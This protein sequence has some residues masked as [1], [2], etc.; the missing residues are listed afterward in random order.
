MAHL[1]MLILVMEKRPAIKKQVLSGVI[2][3]CTD[4]TACA[5]STSAKYGRND[6]LKY[7]ISREKCVY[8][9]LL[10]DSSTLIH[11]AA[12]SQQTETVKILLLLGASIDCQNGSGKTPLHVAVETRNLKVVKCFVEHQATVRRDTELQHVLC[13]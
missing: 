5:L 7:L 9:V 1:E 10:A 8:V 2:C 13:P 12:R 6:V 11:V 3:H 4:N